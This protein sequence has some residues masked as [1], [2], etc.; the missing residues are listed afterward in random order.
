M[1]SGAFADAQVRAVI[2]EFGRILEVFGAQLDLSVR[3]ADRECVAVGAAFH[4]IAAARQTLQQIGAD[5]PATAAIR[6]TA[7]AIG[8]ALNEAVTGLQYQDRLTQRVGHIRVALHRLQGLLRD[9][10]ER[11]TSQ[12]LGILGQVEESNQAEQ[13]R[14]LTREAIAHGSVELF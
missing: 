10:V 9:G 11:S 6:E 12:W 3:E 1:P 13:H 2:E 4:E 7:S 8:R 14:L 5:E